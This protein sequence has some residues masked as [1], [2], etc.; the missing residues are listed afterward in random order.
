M[1]LTV[2]P[3]GPVIDPGAVASAAAPLPWPATGQGA[4]AI[5]S[6]GYSAQSGPEQSVPVASMTKIMTGYLILRD[7]P[8]GPG[9]DGPPITITPADVSYYDQDTA[10]DQANVP[11]AAGEVLSERQMLEGL[12]VHSANDFAYSLGA[13]DAG[14]VPGLR[15]QDERRR[16][17]SSA[18]PRPTTWTRAATYPSPSP[19]RPTC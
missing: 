8:L 7:H 16:R 11:L 4:V 18:W 10:T 9:Q 2:A 14:S 3:K 17:P 6:V 13:W 15:G 1:T 12:L 19:R 5:P